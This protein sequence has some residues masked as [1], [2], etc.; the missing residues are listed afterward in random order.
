[1]HDDDVSS[2]RH[3][4][5]TATVLLLTVGASA[6]LTGCTA[7]PESGTTG[8]VP[9]FTVTPDTAR[10]GDTVTFSTADECDVDVPDGGWRIGV[11]DDRGVR[12][13][14]LVR[15]SG[16]FDGS[17]SVSVPLPADLRSGEG[18][19][20]IENWDYSSCPD[21]ASCAGPFGNLTITR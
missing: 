21:N 9:R 7:S 2:R 3:A 5:V 20:G 11:S 16:T 14:D 12:D 15:S 19:L 17:W 10:A 1:M 4:R 8:C 6:A 13:D 18:M